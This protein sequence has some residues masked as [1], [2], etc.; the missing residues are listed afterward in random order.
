MDG[1]GGGGGGVGRIRLNSLDGN[2]TING[3]LSPPIGSCASVG[4]VTMR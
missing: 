1:G 2:V 4:R 3:T